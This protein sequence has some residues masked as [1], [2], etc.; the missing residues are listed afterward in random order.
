MKAKDRKAWG[1][2]NSRDNAGYELKLGDVVKD[3]RGLRGVVVKI[4]PCNLEWHGTVY[5]WQEER[6]EYGGDNCEHYCH[7][8][9]HEFLRRVV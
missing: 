3:D 7:S 4:V 9:W 2:K 8:N 6:M 5:V 1:E